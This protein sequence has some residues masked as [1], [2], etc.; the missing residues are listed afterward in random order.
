[1]LLLIISVYYYMFR[2]IIIGAKYIL[3]GVIKNV[4]KA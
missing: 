3:N 2:C 1:M 4:L